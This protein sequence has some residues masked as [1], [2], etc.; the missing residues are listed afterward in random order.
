MRDFAWP[1]V[2]LFAPAAGVPGLTVFVVATAGFGGFG[3]AAG[4]CAKATLDANATMVAATA[5]FILASQ[6]LFW[7]S[8][9]SGN[10]WFRGGSSRIFP[11]RV[12]LKDKEGPFPP[13]DNESIA[14]LDRTGGDD[15]HHHETRSRRY[16][17]RGP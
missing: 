12:E 15:V 13:M 3:L 9:A 10:G 8:N 16:C 1:S 11:A 4:T 2:K 6:H 5:Y 14:G 17:I 7:N